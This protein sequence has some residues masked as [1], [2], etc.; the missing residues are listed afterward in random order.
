MAPGRERGGRFWTSSM[1]S[2]SSGSLAVRGRIEARQ[3]V[4]AV[5]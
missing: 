4:P 1:V 5:P 3:Q 2:L